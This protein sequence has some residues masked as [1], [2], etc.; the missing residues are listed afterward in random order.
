MDIDLKAYKEQY[1]LEERKLES[2]EV[3]DKYPKR[4]PVIIEKYK[5]CS[6]TI[7]NITKKKFLVPNDITIGQFTYII[8]KR[9][10]LEAEHAIF[11]FVGKNNIPPSSKL[12][13]E[14]YTNYKDEDGF[15]YM[16]YSGENTFG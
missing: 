1:S 4:V 13:S 12:I 9:I 16:V 15:L 3:I 6:N 11:L 7:P 14:I 2:S 10:K 5:E 8:R